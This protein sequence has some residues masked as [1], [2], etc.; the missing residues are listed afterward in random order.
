[1]MGD[2]GEG[3]SFNLGCLR[4][5][6]VTHL[7]YA[8]IMGM[9]WEYNWQFW[10]NFFS[11]SLAFLYFVFF[12][13]RAYWPGKPTLDM[14]L[15]NAEYTHIYIYVYIHIHVCIYVDIYIYYIYTYLYIYI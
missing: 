3:W 9:P 1:M 8:S 6:G 14:G 2:H 12:F 5:E 15:S 4:C 13:G 10:S 11:D 7:G